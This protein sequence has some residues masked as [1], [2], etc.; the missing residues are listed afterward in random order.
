MA[1][2]RNLISYH[3]SIA[4]E[5]EATKNRVRDLIGSSHW[6][7]DGEHKEAV[8]RKALRNYL[9]ENV[10]VGKGFVCYK[11]GIPQTS[12]QLDILIVSKSRPTLFKDGEFVIVTPDAVKAI[13]EVKTKISSRD[14]LLEALKKLGEDAQRIR[15][16]KKNCQGEN[17]WSGLFIY[18]DISLDY[19]VLL[20][21]CR[22]A[23]NQDVLRAVNCISGG[24]SKFIRFW[25]NGIE[26]NS[27]VRGPVW[28][29]YDLKDLAPAYFLSNLV[30]YV[31][32]GMQ[33]DMQ[34]AWFPIEKGKETRRRWYIPL[35]SG[36]A[37]EFG[38]KELPKSF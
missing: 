26:A 8:L 28:H 9:P 35:N 30:W 21:A 12:K 31:T 33:R 32:P 25:R 24:A 13:V 4:R 7:S 23:A 15:N 18:D 17:C 29:A 10:L 6:Q 27:P 37:K 2:E 16:E 5:L 38:D 14:E 22:D 36:E 3:R 19:Q 11:S 20:E 34:Y 1:I